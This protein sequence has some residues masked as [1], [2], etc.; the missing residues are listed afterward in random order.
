MTGGPDVTLDPASQLL[1]LDDHGLP[2][3][4][5]ADRQHS[6]VAACASIADDERTRLIASL[7]F[8]APAP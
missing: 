8:D 5:G 3:Q 4:G 7:D 1:L 2:I 6:Q